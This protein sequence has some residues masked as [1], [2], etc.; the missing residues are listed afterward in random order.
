MYGKLLSITKNSNQLNG[1]STIPQAYCMK[2]NSL[3]SKYYS[4][5][6]AELYDGRWIVIETGDGQVSGLASG[7]S[8]DKYYEE[9][10][11]IIYNDV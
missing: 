3:P 10:L 8:V 9:M 6:F 5:D 7:Q 11:K 1:C 2:F 4:I